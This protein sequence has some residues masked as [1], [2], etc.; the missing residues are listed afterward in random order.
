MTTFLVE[1]LKSGKVTIS[2][3]NKP[4]L[5]IKVRNKRIDVDAK[6]NTLIKEIVSST[7][8]GTGKG[9]MKERIQRTTNILSEARESRPL[10]KDMVEDLCAE[11]VTIT[12]SYKGD[13]VA[14]IGSDANSKVTRLLTGTK[15]IEI[16]N[17]RK[18][19]E[20]GLSTII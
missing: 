13:K 14:T 2:E 4:Q 16:N 19:A 12:L 18:L 5:E 9:S 15:G 20:L 8:K 7:A 6:D 17:P 10:V 3:S 1:S 11:G